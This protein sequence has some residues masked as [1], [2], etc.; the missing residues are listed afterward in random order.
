MSEASEKMRQEGILANWALDK[1]TPKDIEAATDNLINK[2]QQEYDKVG[3]LKPEELNL[4]NCIE[5]TS[6]NTNMFVMH[7]FHQ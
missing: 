5:V 6:N 2:A 3:R 1:L 4:Q 7:F